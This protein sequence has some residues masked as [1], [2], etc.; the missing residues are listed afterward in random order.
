MVIVFFDFA[1]PNKSI[2]LFVNIDLQLIKSRTFP[3]TE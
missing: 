2:Y 3:I 1:N